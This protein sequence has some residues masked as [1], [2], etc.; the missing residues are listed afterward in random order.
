MTR[1]LAILVLATSVAYADQPA[2]PAA[3]ATPA[4]PAAPADTPPTEPAAALREANAAATAGDWTKVAAY[5]Q[6]L[7]ARS[8]EPTDLGEAHRLAGLAAFFGNHLPE[9]E[10][11]FF[12]YLKLDLDGHLDPAL[13]PPEVVNFFYDVRARHKA[14]L[15][16]L[17]PPTKR[18]AVLNLVPPFGQFQNG[19]RTK[20]IVVGSLLG[21]FLVANVTSYLVVRSWCHNPGSTC[22]DSGTDHF[23]RANQLTT[24]NTLT[25]LGAIVTYIYG[26]WDGVSGYRR[27]TREQ[28]YTPYVAPSN[29]GAMIGVS[30]R[31]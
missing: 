8:L 29:D 11:H 25:G 31:F 27:R 14:E 10:Q 16:A 13:Y 9:A 19:E 17:R 4:G 1:A 3:P 24:V 18:Y 20:G 6:P 26:V 7:L 12:A 30:T 21:A 28:R 22:D 5:V 23:R 15:N 2:V